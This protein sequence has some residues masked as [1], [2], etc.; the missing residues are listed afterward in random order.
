MCTPS[1]LANDLWAPQPPPLAS[2]LKKRTCLQ[3]VIQGVPTSFG[4]T[5]TL[6]CMRWLIAMLIYDLFIARASCKKKK[7]WKCNV[8]QFEFS[9][10]SLLHLVI[11]ETNETY[12]IW[13]LRFKTFFFFES[14]QHFC[15]YA[16][17][18]TVFKKN[19]LNV[20]FEFSLAKNHVD[21][22]KIFSVFAPEMVEIHTMLIFK[23]VRLF[24][25]VNTFQSLC[26]FVTLCLER[27]LIF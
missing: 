13:E 19:Y 16:E 15:N 10:E 14:Q 1:S 27:N 11:R 6:S 9:T 25:Y 4:V 12:D 24:E 7:L 21:T 3:C 18:T 23:K 17:I 8:S 5:F 22:I 20:W 26:N 2:S